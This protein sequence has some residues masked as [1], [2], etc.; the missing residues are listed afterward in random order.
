LRRTY[1]AATE[2]SSHANDALMKAAA[3]LVSTVREKTIAKVSMPIAPSAAPAESTAAAICPRR[4]PGKA[5]FALAADL[6]LLD[7]G[8]ARA[9]Y[10]WKREEKTSDKCAVAAADKA[11]EYGRGATEREADHVFVPAPFLQR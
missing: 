6:V 4:S 2:I 8:G 10:G 7:Q 5:S 11:G 3:M 1:Q 9:E